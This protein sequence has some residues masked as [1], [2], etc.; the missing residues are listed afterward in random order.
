MRL[1]SLYFV[2]GCQ[3][4]LRALPAKVR[5]SFGYALYLA[6]LGDRHPSAKALKGFGG[7]GVVEVVEDD[8]GGTYRVMYTVKFKD[9]VFVL[10]AFQKKSK[11]GISTPL[12]QMKLVGSRLRLAE[13]AYNAMEHPHG[14]DSN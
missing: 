5:Q 10:H 3:K 11:R 1:K 7:G 12:A 4:D 6:Q 14:Q 9:A 13:E 8:E 2:S